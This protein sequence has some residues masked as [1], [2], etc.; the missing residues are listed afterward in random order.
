MHNRF[1]VGAHRTM[2]TLILL[3][4]LLFFNWQLALS[5]LTR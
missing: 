5:L 4:I 2:I 3:L 1:Q